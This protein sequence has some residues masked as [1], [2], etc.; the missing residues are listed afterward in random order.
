MLYGSSSKDVSFLKCDKRKVQSTIS[1]ACS[2]VL[3]GRG[4]IECLS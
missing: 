2:A 4:E 3:L 1:I